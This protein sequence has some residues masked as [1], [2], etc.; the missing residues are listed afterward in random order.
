MALVDF[1]GVSFLDVSAEVAAAAAPVVLET[2]AIA[3][4]LP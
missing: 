4:A 2:T 1:T 3:N